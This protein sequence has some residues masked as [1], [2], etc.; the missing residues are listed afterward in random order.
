MR[1]ALF[2][3]DGTITEQDSFGLFAR[4]ASSASR[5][6]LAGPFVGACLA[7]YRSKLLSDDGLCQA[8]VSAAFCGR[9]ISV[10]QQQAESFAAETVP[11]LVRSWSHNRLQEH[12][13][14]GDRIVVVSASLDLYLKPW[15]KAQGY[16]LLCSRLEVIRGICSGRFAATQCRGAEKARLIQGLCKLSD[17]SE[18]IA[19][20][21]S[22]GDEEM[23]ALADRKFYRGVERRT[24]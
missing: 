8:V 3:F 10:L 14:R 16:D 19:Y 24:T 21:D 15:C 4:Q 6:A 17:Y 22:S 13:D 11:G 2:D 1:L 7:A 5:A 23:L 18:I 12:R 20:G 9:R